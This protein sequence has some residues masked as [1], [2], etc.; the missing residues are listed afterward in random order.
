MGKEFA[1][2]VTCLTCGRTLAAE[3]AIFTSSYWLLPCSSYSQ[4][5]ANKH[6]TSKQKTMHLLWSLL[7]F[8]TYFDIDVKCKHIAGVS[9]STTDHL[10]C[11]NL[12]SFFHLH[13]QATCQ[14]TP[15][16][17]PLLQILA[18]GCQTGHHPYSSSR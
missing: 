3:L 17:Q 15:L 6:C 5:C 12:H 18:I 1:S 4:Y 11:S 8:V 13:P 2:T 16:P 14:Q 7:F 9:N 10:S